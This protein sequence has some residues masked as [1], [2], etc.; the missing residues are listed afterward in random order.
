AAVATSS[1]AMLEGT[2]LY[3]PSHNVPG[4]DLE[5]WQ[6]NG[7]VIGY[8]HVVAVPKRVW[9]MFHGNGGQASQ[10]G[11]IRDSLPATDAVFIMEYPGYGLRAGT[12]SMQSINTAALEAY[13]DLLRRYPKAPI[14][15]MGE[16]L[17]SGPASF[18]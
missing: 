6:A 13:A 7:Q 15:I 8:A 17:G 3:F 2:F 4:S 11:Y 12:P 16:S 1:F 5:P 14:A 9:L 18:I 10:R